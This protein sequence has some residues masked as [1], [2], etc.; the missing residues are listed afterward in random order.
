VFLLRTS[1]RSLGVRY[2]ETALN[3]AVQ[4]LYH[5]HRRFPEKRSFYEA[6]FGAPSLWVSVF[7]VGS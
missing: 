6:R 1:L 5:S 2:T 4:K 3:T 7:V